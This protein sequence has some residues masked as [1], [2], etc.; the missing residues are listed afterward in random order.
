MSDAHRYSWNPDADGRSARFRFRQGL[1]VVPNSSDDAC[2]KLVT[3]VLNPETGKKFSF[4][5]DEYFLCECANGS[6]T[7]WD[8]QQLY[9]KRFGRELSTA[10]LLSFY[11]RL[12]ILGLLDVG[13]SDAGGPGAGAASA[14]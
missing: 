11:R 5:E 3:W 7:L 8:I 12:R 14:S 9:S 1:T 4:R 13:S 2:D 6:N 10:D